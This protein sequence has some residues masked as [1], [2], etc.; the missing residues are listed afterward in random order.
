MKESIASTRMG[1][2]EKI[3]REAGIRFNVKVL[4]DNW[5]I[6]LENR[7]TVFTPFLPAGHCEPSHGRVQ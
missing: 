5:C 3:A 6:V 7:K 1:K 2:D 4:T